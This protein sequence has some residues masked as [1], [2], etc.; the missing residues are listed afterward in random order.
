LHVVDFAIVL[1][2]CRN[3]L[4]RNDFRYARNKENPTYEILPTRL[5]ATSGLQAPWPEG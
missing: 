3:L 1:P 4:P 5:L 2:L